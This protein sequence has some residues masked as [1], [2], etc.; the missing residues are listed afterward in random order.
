MRS[1]LAELLVFRIGGTG[2]LDLWLL[3][4]VRTGDPGR[5]VGLLLDGEFLRIE[6][7][8]VLQAEIP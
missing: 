7:S 4:Q 8:G 3:L 5:T 2:S 6:F 1:L